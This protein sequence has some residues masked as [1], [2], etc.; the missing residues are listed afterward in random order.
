M[1][2]VDS[3][4]DSTSKWQLD[5]ELE[6]WRILRVKIHFCSVK[7]D[8]IQRVVTLGHVPNSTKQAFI[9]IL[10]IFIQIFI[11]ISN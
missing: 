5:T 11:F 8:S 3:S 9:K 10:Q 1:G 7:F 4:R 6:L 2:V